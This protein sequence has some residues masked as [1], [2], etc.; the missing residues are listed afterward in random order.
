MN[1]AKDDKAKTNLNTQNF[2]SGYG[3]DAVEKP[4][5]AITVDEIL[6][7]IK[8]VSVPDYEERPVYKLHK[9]VLEA[10]IDEINA[11]NGDKDLKYI[12]K[13]WRQEVHVFESIK[14]LD[15]RGKEERYKSVMDP[16]NTPL[17]LSFT[18]VRN[19][20]PLNVY[21]LFKKYLFLC[22]Y[23]LPPYGGKK[24]QYKHFKLDAVKKRTPKKITCPHCGETFDK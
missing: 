1:K 22:K 6:T 20:K 23:G 8:K 2:Y 24:N 15:V 11:N 12:L 18:E 16:N 7:A 13:A 5:M 19:E 9:Q 3:S 14:K 17:L 10:S 21:Q 4:P